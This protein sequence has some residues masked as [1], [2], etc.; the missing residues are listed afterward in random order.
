MS[1]KDNM[2]L[3][4]GITNNILFIDD[5]TSPEKIFYLHNILFRTEISSFC[6]FQI[7]IGIDENDMIINIIN[8]QL[9]FL[10][11]KLH[12]YIGGNYDIDF[13]KTYSNLK[14]TNEN[15]IIIIEEEVFLFFDYESVNSTGHS[16]DLMFYLLY[17]Y[18][19]FNITAKLLVV[20]S[21]NKYYNSTLS[22]IKKYFNIEYIYILPNKTYL[23]KNFLC[24]RNYQNIL[25]KKVKEFINT[26]LII[27]IINNY[28]ENNNIYYKSISKIKY[29]D[30]INAVNLFNN[31]YNKTDKL[32]SFVKE[33]EIFDLNNI[34]HDE[35]LKIYLINKSSN[36][37]LS[38]G[39]IYYIYINYYLLST[40]NKYISIIFHPSIMSGH[41]MF[42]EKNNIYYQQMHS[43]YTGNYNNMYNLC[44]FKGEIIYNIDN[45]D[46]YIS[47]TKIFN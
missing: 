10:L 5:Y 33:N 14:Q 11:L 38:F 37:I 9:S 23:F 44:T 12:H 31:S 16:Y 36:I 25:F 41:K 3:R 35:E 30:E 39:S 19:L 20:E 2:L 17:Y 45:I 24:I 1:F 29:K 13:K 27:P 4:L 15:D 7:P 46:D 21:N 8:K 18:K 32:I 47:K 34:E 42:L 28:T 6:N 43:D 26:N 40:D 22:L